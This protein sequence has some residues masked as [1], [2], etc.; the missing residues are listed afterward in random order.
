MELSPAMRDE[1]EG[2]VVALDREVEAYSKDIVRWEASE[3]EA[4]R[5]LASAKS[6]RAEYAA[7][8]DGGF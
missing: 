7:L 5:R 8:L 6:L 3:A 1:I 2:R 4:A